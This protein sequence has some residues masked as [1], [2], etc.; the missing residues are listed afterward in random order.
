M[1]LPVNLQKPFDSTDLEWIDFYKNHLEV[2]QERR[3]LATTSFFRDLSA[4]SGAKAPD[5]GALYFGQYEG[6]HVIEWYMSAGTH[7]PTGIVAAHE[8][9]RSLKLYADNLLIVVSVNGVVVPITSEKDSDRLSKKFFDNALQAASD[10]YRASLEYKKQQ[11]D[12]ARYVSNIAQLIERLR[13]KAESNYFIE[14]D[15]DVKHARVL[16]W[17]SVLSKHNDHV[18]LKHDKIE[19]ISFVEKVGYERDDAL[20]LD[21]KEYEV[22]ETRARYIAG[23]AISMMR[24]GMPVH[25]SF[26]YSLKERLADNSLFTDELK[27]LEQEMEDGLCLSW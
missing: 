10:R 9:L 11:E 1:S 17:L 6:Q 26:Y 20:H 5:D 3:S 23:Q 13:A 25:P 22:L 16:A 18:D 8:W 4:R 19:L 27:K 21:K 7:I 14:H 15:G 2:S 24:S 12:R